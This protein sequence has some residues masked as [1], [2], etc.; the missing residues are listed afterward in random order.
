MRHRFMP[1]FVVAGIGRVVVFSGDV[2]VEIE[3]R[4]SAFVDALR[5]DCDI[6]L[7][8]LDYHE[9]AVSAGADAQAAAYIQIRDSGDATL[10]GVGMDSDIVTASLRAVASAATRVLHRT[11]GW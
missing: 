9:D 5:R 6:A 11:R 1:V 2:N 3:C 8:G 10:Y 7:N 4:Q